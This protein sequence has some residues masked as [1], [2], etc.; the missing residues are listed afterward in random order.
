MEVGEGRR[1]DREKGRWREGEMK[2]RCEGTIYELRITGGRKGDGAN[3]I[4][5]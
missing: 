5:R 2:R 4:G 1:G 3:E